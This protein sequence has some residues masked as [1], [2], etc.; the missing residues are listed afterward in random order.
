MISNSTD[1]YRLGGPV[2]VA[3]LRVSPVAVAGTWHSAAHLVSTTTGT[4]MGGFS[5][6]RTTR[7]FGDPT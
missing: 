6:K 5:T 3:R 4:P 2:E 1:M 7:P